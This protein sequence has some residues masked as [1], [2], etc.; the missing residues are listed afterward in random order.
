MAYVLDSIA[1][2][3]INRAGNRWAAGCLAI[4]LIFAVLEGL[5]AVWV[6]TNPMYMPRVFWDTY[7]RWLWP[8]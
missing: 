4:F 5:L 7:L 8:S 3:V 6:I 1:F 2:T